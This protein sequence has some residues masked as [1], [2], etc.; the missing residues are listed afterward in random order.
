M[1]LFGNETK[2][3]LQQIMCEDWAEIL[4]SYTTK[5]EVQNISKILQIERQKVKVY[6]E[7]IDVFKA[8]TYPFYKIKV[9][10]IGQDPYFN[11]NADGLAFS[12]KLNVSPSLQQILKAMSNDL[13]KIVEF[14]PTNRFDLEYLAEQ[15]VFL[16][17]P[18]LTVQENNPGNHEI[19]WKQFSRKV[20]YC[21]YQNKKDLIVTAWGQKAQSIHHSVIGIQSNKIL[22]LNNEHPAAAAR[23]NR[24]WKCDH[25]SKINTYLKDLRKEE[26]KWL[27]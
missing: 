9:V 6:P 24:I 17:N 26:I 8:F 3:Y 13:Q 5:E 21:L 20:L 11:G 19:I 4:S 22:Y 15:G 14:I 23:E 27:L 10:I 7:G 16:F 12:C 1:N 25:F 2:E 18:S